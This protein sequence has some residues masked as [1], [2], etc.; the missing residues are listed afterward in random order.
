[1]W[2]GYYEYDWDHVREGRSFEC[3]LQKFADYI[4]C[5]KISIQLYSMINII[6]IVIVYDNDNNNNKLKYLWV[7]L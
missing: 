4:I 1:M 7:F 3:I 6:F 2:K 5:K